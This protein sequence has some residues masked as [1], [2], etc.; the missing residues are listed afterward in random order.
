MVKFDSSMGQI[1]ST[2]DL[3]KL[4]Q[5]YQKQIR[6]EAAVYLHKRGITE[7]TVNTFQIG[8]D[9]DKIGFLVNQ[10]ALGDY[11]ANRI[12]IP[13]KNIEGDPVDLIG[14]AIDHR[15]PKYKSLFGIDDLLFNQQVLVESED[16]VLC[17]GIFD[18]LT[19]S[20]ENIPAVCIPTKLNL[21]KEY[22]ASLMKGK[23]VFICLGNDDA[24]RRES[25]RIAGVLGEYVQDVYIVNL[26][27]NIRDINDLFVRTQNPMEIFMELLN[28]SIEDSLLE[29]VAPDYRHLII[30]NEEYAKRYRGQVKP[31]QTGLAGLDEALH[32]GLMSGLYLLSGPSSCGKSL[33]LKQMADYIALE[34]TPVIYFS[35]DHSHFECWARSIARILAVPS[36]KVIRGLIEPERIQQANQTYVEISKMLWTIECT[37]QT[38]LDTMVA[39]I[40]QVLGMVDR[41]P[42]IFI[43]HLQ[44]VPYS[45]QAAGSVYESHPG[46]T[47]ALKQLS[48][49]WNTPV[50]AA[51]QTPPE[52]TELDLGVE[53]SADVVWHLQRDLFQRQ[54]AALLF[55]KHRYG[56]LNKINLKFEPEKTVFAQAE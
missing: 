53:A 46:V 4:V 18:V 19:L 13:L 9:T 49:E 43:D 21:F 7:E 10:D 23:R 38:T 1:K 34:Q 41:A 14:R 29:P 44:R 33:F 55:L 6:D 48:T 30:F 26:P 24:G 51:V 8:F 11:F 16:V 54:Q 5:R 50:I 36:F 22:H 52:S 45:G 31:I 56:T 40:E 12:I 32:G 39:S 47:Y 2:F 42:V 35:W 28:K 3:E 20:Q 25:S 37:Y 17:T 15:E 27:E